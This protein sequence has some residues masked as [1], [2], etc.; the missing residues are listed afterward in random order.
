MTEYRIHLANDW[1][2]G[3]LDYGTNCTVSLDTVPN[4]TY[5]MTYIAWDTSDTVRLEAAAGPAGNQLHPSEPGGDVQ[6][7][8][9]YI[10][11]KSVEQ[12]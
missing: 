5:P 12:L 2:F 4:A 10:R 11:L 8:N 3:N 7:G 6:V 1:T 9:E